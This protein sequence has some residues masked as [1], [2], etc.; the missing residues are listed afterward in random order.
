[1][2]LLWTAWHKSVS[3]KTT[4]WIIATVCNCHSIFVDLLYS[5]VIIYG[6]IALVYI[7]AQHS[8]TFCSHSGTSLLRWIILGDYHWALY[9]SFQNRYI[10]YWIG[11]GSTFH[12][13]Y[14]Y[15]DYACSIDDVI[16][17]LPPTTPQDSTRIGSVKRCWDN[18]LWSE[19]RKHTFVHNKVSYLCWWILLICFCTSF[20]CKHSWFLEMTVLSQQKLRLLTLDQHAWKIALFTPIFRFDIMLTSRF[21][22]YSHIAYKSFINNF[23]LLCRA[24]I[25]DLLK[26]FLGISI[27]VNELTSLYHC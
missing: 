15:I 11:F 5:S 2:H 20:S 6:L 27:L 16:P 26:F 8:L 19:A 1:M 17:I 21:P 25:T 18:P 23:N 22:F 14:W 24:G 7:L 3:H 4:Y 10:S 12:F 9:N 13:S